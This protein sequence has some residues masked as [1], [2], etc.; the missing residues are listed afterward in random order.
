MRHDILVYSDTGT[1]TGSLIPS[2]SDSFSKRHFN[3]RRITAQDIADGALRQPQ[4]R[5]FVLPGITG[6]ISPYTD[7][8]REN[9]LSEIHDFVRRGPNVLMTICAGSYFISRQTVYSP[10][11]SQPRGRHSAAPL[12]NG[13]AAGPVPGYARP[14]GPDC[15][16]DDVITVPVTYQEQDGTWSA[17]RVCYG[18]GPAFFPD[19]PDVD[20]LAR[21]GGVPGEPPAILR[22][23]FGAGHVYLCGILPDIA[24]QHVTPL[25]QHESAR[26]LMNEL[27]PEEAGRKK[28]WTSLTNRIKQDLKP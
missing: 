4:A 5:I 17:A 2:L 20:I 27:K 9:A 7:Q 23:S 1:A 19:T 16:F 18:N 25:Q 3:I 24:Y 21:Y 8:M 6:D 22:R 15:R 11:W 26:R 13:V 14:S 10:P 28:L 12:F